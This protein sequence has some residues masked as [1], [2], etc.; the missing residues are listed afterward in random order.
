MPE[1]IKS[2]T[3]LDNFKNVITAPASSV[4]GISK[5]LVLLKCVQATKT[6]RENL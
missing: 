6:S 3:Y 2:L 1:E 5:L 4:N